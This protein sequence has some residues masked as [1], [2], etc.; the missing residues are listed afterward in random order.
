MSAQRRDLQRS[1][2]Q[3]SR[4]IPT[5]VTDEQT[6]ELVELTRANAE[7]AAAS[8]TV[9][10]RSESQARIAQAQ[11]DRMAGRIFWLTVVLVVHPPR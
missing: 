3:L 10:E 9:L 2:D 8:L 4:L 6:A 5:P 11:A 7:V 1:I